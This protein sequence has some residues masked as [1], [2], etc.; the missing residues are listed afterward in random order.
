[1]QNLDESDNDNQSQFIALSTR[2]FTIQM[3]SKLVNFLLY[4]LLYHPSI[5]T[6]HQTGVEI[7]AGCWWY[8]C[9]NCVE[10]QDFEQINHFNEVVCNIHSR[11]NSIDLVIC[12][13]FEVIHSTQKSKRSNASTKHAFYIK[14]KKRNET[15]AIGKCIVGKICLFFMLSHHS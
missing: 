13:H 7:A 3:K 8:S 1:M 4:Q 12:F 14:K 6:I 11:L 15:N 2:K 9:I 5:Q 10:W